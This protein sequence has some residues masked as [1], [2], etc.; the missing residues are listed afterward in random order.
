L[1][2][3]FRRNERQL[4]T[5]LCDSGEGHV[6]SFYST[7]FSSLCAV[8]AVDYTRAYSLNLIYTLTF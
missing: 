3:N 6:F 1:S 5:T 7:I 2:E 8:D 4:P